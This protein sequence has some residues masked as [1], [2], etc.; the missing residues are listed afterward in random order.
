MKFLIY[1]L[2]IVAVITLFILLTSYICFYMAFYVP[3]RK[4]IPGDEISIPEGDIYEPYRDHMTRWILETRAMPH[5]DV[6]I[7]SFDGLKL[8]GKYYEY[9]PDAPIE[10][11]FHGY[12]GSAERDLSG[13]VQRCFSLGRNVLLVDQRTSAG[14]EGH[15]ISFGVNESR[16]CLSWIDFIIEHYGKDSRIILTGISMGAATVMMAAGRGLP[17]N[18]IGILA[19]CGY[20]SPKAIIKKTI[21]EMKLPP[22]LLYPFVKL[23]ARIFGHFDLEETSPIEAMKHCKVPVIFIHG[24]ADDFVPCDMSRQVYQICTC[25][26]LLVTVPGAGH[27][28]GYIVDLKGYLNAVVDFSTKYITP[29]SVVNWPMQ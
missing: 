6:S 18:V 4:N 3:R 14:S 21:R 16:D 15:V 20:S 8:C 2:V 19:D 25:P 26:K 27:G 10:L 23:G 22:A 17:D 11:M 29:T 12:R 5:E 9:A 24:E 13:G 1:L 28:L 7:R